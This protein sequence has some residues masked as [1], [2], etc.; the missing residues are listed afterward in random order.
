MNVGVTLFMGLVA[1][2]VA[3]S[4]KYNVVIKIATVAAAT[5]LTRF[6]DWR[7]YGVLWIL[8]FGLFHDSFAKQAIFF[9][10]VALTRAWGY[11]GSLYNITMNCAVLLALPLLYFYSGEKGKKPRYGFYIFYPA[12]LLV[13]GIIKLLITT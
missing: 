7:Y 9:A 11:S 10:I 3:K 12:H 4:D 13:L 6:S 2:S 8:V 5:Y 1:L